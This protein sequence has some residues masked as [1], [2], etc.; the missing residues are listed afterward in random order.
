MSAFATYRGELR[1]SAWPCARSRIAA[2][3]ALVLGIL[4]AGNAAAQVVNG[5]FSSGGTGW[6]TTIPSNSTLSFAS[7]RLTTVSDDNGGANSRT[8]ASQTITVSDPGFLTWL[9]VSYTSVD[10]DLG[11]YDY[12]MVLL[13]S[14]FYWIT[15]AG[16]LTTTAS[17]GIDNDNTGITNVTARTTLTAG[18]YP[19]G[20]G[21]TSSD[22]GFGPG[23]A[24][25]DNIEFQQLTQSPSAQT[26]PEDTP[27]VLSGANK[28]AVATNSGVATLTVTVSV[29]NGI[30][31]LA[32]TTGLTITA[33][34]NGS[35]SMTFTGSATNI[36]NALNGITYVPTTNFNGSSV[37]TFSAT[38]GALSDTDT[39]NI[40]VTPVPDYMFTIGKVA[41]LGNVS[42]V[43]ATI[44]YTI[45]VQN[46]G[47]TAM[48]GTTITDDLVQGVS[49]TGM[50]VSGPTGDGAPV[51]VFGV[52]ETWVYTT[53]YAVTQANLDNGA[54]LVNTATFDTAEMS[55]ASASATTTITQSPSMSIAKTADDTTDVIVGQTVT[56]TY[57]VTNTG[58]ITIDSVAVNDVHPGSGPDPVPANET[59]SGDVA[60]LGDSTDATGN[61]GV[62]S[63]LSPG[64]AVTFTGTYVVTQSD[65][66][67][68]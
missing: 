23:T 17:A 31:N 4:G 18:T 26:T 43:G 57:V 51:G 48:T 32:S 61:N 14:T 33:G 46:T 65:V 22:S 15:T 42:T 56:Y 45:T 64:D 9:L 68:F 67:T 49:S 16:A 1:L 55:P 25:W 8:Y 12:P 11:P 21:V 24:V 19:I 58:N 62:W 63:T 2:T 40:T 54:N 66:D 10:R 5:D 6:S 36:N 47:D 50:L 53:A 30:L 59:L 52:G 38:A 3:A 28:L 27:L 39:I 34:A 13:N 29:T 35:A 44:N 37:L 41:S 7:A 60:P 20:A